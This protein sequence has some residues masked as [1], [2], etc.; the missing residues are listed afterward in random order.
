MK[1]LFMMLSVVMLNVT[2]Y[3]L[4]CCVCRYA[5]SHYAVC[6]YAECRGAHLALES[7]TKR[8]GLPT[9]APGWLI[10]GRVTL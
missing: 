9:L 1:M 2:F 10:F 5:E 8:K 3:L 7:L 4:L 6:R